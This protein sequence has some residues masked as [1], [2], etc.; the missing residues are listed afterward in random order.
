MN[1]HEFFLF[2]NLANVRLSCFLS[3][4]GLVSTVVRRYDTISAIVPIPL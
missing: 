1:V 2:F 4:D 3:N